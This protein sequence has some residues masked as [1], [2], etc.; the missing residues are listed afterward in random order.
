MIGFWIAMFLCSGAASADGFD[1]GYID[2]GSG[3]GG[4]EQITVVD[5]GLVGGGYAGAGGV[6]DWRWMAMGEHVGSSDEA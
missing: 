6:R 2:A 5:V 4:T 1:S 3:A